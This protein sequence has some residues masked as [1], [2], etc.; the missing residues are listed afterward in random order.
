MSISDFERAI[1]EI[2]DMLVI[3][4]PLY[5]NGYINCK[6]VKILIDTGA[7]SSI[8]YNSTINRLNLND[9]VDSTYKTLLSGIGLEVSVGRIWYTNLQMSDYNFPVSLVVSNND[10]N[11]I[12]IILGMNFLKACNAILD[13]K[14]MM[15]QIKINNKKININFSSE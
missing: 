12:D 10:I 6:P 8:I 7:S 11:N 1:N 3:S 14:N 9:K 2:P 5:I 15:L 13:L 4:E